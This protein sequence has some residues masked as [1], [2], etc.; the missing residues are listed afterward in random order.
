MILLE[1]FATQLDIG[2]EMKPMRYAG[3]VGL[4]SHWSNRIYFSSLFISFK[5]FLFGGSHLR[6]VNAPLEYEVA[7]EGW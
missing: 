1:N 2:K 3:F 4:H 7:N 5:D 6:F